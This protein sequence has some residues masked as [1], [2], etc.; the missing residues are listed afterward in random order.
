MQTYIGY[1]LLTIFVRLKKEKEKQLCSNL[2]TDTQKINLEIEMDKS[3]RDQVENNI[4]NGI[5]NINCQQNI[6]KE[7]SIKSKDISTR[8]IQKR[9]NNI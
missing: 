2:P 1:I 3:D 4:I 9:K 5:N 8:N 6:V 7:I